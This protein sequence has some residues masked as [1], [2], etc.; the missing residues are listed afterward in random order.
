LGLGFAQG[1][2]MFWRRADLEAAGGIGA[3]GVEIAEDAASTKIVR[4]AGLRVRLTEPPFGQPLGRR[5]ITEVWRRQNRW[6]RLRRSCFPLYF[7][8]EI[9]GGAVFPLI[10]AGYVADVAG[11][12]VF[13]TIV[14]L[15]CL[16]YGAEAMLAKAAR[17]HL[18]PL[19]PLH[20]LL[21]DLLLPV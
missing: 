3:L 6:A 8:P 5:D 14:A 4:N 18:A 12:S 13:G 1:K 20:A 11:M 2:T 21:R 10:A 16:W 9:L 7:A 19:Y 17:W 15:S